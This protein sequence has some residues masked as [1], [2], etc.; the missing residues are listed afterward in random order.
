MRDSRGQFT[1]SETA[2]EENGQEHFGA[3]QPAPAPSPTRVGQRFPRH[4]RGADGRRRRGR[5]N[6]RLVDRGLNEDE[7]EG[8]GCLFQDSVRLPGEYRSGRYVL[9]ARRL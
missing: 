5:R 6:R 1:T 8:T 3:Q 4:R 7:I 9:A 2:K